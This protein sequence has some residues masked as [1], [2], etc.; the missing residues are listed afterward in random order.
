[1]T[2]AMFRLD[3]IG[4]DAGTGNVVTGDERKR[5]LPVF[6][7]SVEVAEMLRISDRTLENWRMAKRGPNAIR[8]GKGGRAKVIYSLDEVLRWLKEDGNRD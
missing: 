4:A 7:E 6:L 3:L 8:L 2:A 1:M 5:P